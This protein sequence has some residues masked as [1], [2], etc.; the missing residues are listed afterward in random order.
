M[1][2]SCTDGVWKLRFK[3]ISSQ[4]GDRSSDRTVWRAGH[5]TP[6][7]G[8]LGAPFSVSVGTAVSALFL[9]PQSHWVHSPGP[10]SQAPPQATWAPFP[11][12]GQRKGPLEPALSFKGPGWSNVDELDNSSLCSIKQ[13]YTPA[14]LASF[15]FGHSVMADS[16]GPHGLQHTRLSCPSPTPGAC[17]KSCP[18]SQ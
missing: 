6:T 7:G 13:T 1:Q 11:C 18:L 15:Q 3:G 5:A 10:S 8:I 9:P 14:I 12:Q 17:S 4:V 2:L 16:L